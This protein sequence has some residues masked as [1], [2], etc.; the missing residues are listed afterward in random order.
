MIANYSDFLTSFISQEWLNC[1]SQRY[2][3][4]W[5]HDDIMAWEHFPHYSWWRHQMETF[6]AFPF[7]R[8]IHRSPVNS[9]HKG[10]WR[11]ALMFTLICARINGWVN[12][13]E[14]GDLRR[15][16][17][18]YDVIVMWFRNPC[19]Q[20]TEDWCIPDTKGQLCRT[21]IVYVLL[22][23]QAFE[24]TAE[25]PLKWDPLTHGG[26]AKW[27]QFCSRHFQMHFLERKYMNF[28]HNFTEFCS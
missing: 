20:S 22:V 13:C 6:S 25:W 18:H 12:N 19:G 11:G 26:R 9:P 27:L 2:H 24:Q 10:Q 14:A 4:Y 28:D 16:R 17:A 23:R 5:Q 1:F 8:R 7:V 21:L 3:H 15:N